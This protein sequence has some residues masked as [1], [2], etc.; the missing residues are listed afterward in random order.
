MLRA[1]RCLGGFLG[2]EKHNQAYV[3]VIKGEHGVAEETR[4]AQ[5][6]TRVETRAFFKIFKRQ[7]LK[8]AHHFWVSPPVFAFTTRL[9]QHGSDLEHKLYVDAARRRPRR[10]SL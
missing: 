7:G 10:S 4:D 1:M 2:G 6:N 3:S 8:I 9:A 5:A